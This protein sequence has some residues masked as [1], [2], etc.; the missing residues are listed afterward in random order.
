[1][2]EA[3]LSVA[4]EKLAQHSIRAPFDG[5]V[6]HTMVGPG[7]SIKIGMPLVALQKIQETLIDAWIDEG[8]LRHVSQGSLCQ[9]TLP[10]ISNQVLHGEVAA[11]VGIANTHRIVS[12]IAPAYDRNAIWREHAVVLVRIRLQHRFSQPLPAGA[13]CAV[14]IQKNRPSRNSSGLLVRDPDI[15]FHFE[16][17]SRPANTLNARASSRAKQRTDRY[18][19]PWTLTPAT[20]FCAYC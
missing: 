14:R 20:G 12:E 19:D 11:V 1:M 8:T 13:T 15:L 6:L 4:L 2:A 7:A 9:I 5:V 10:A 18:L 3:D 17:P 16:G